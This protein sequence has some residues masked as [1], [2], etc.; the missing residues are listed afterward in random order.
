ME[1]QYSCRYW[2]YHLERSQVLS[3]EIEDLYLFLQKHF[4][5]WVE[6]MSLF[7]LVSKVVGMLDLLHMVV[8]NDETSDLSNFLYDGKRFILKYCQIADEAPLQIYCAGL[9]D[10]PVAITPVWS[11]A[12]SPDSRLLASGSWDNTVRLWDTAT[13]ALQQTFEGHSHYVRSVAFS[14]DG[15]LLASGS[16]DNIVRTWDTA[17]GALQKT[18]EA[19]FWW[20]WSVTFS[21]D[22]R[23]LASGCEDDRVRLW[24]SATGELQHILKGHSN[25]VTSVAFSPDGRLLASGSWD[26]SVCLWDIATGSLQ[27]TWDFQVIVTVFEFSHDGSYLHTS[28]GGIDTQVGCAIS[29]FNSPHANLEISEDHQWIKL[30]GE[31]VLWLPP[32]SRPDCF[33]IKGSKLA[34]G[35]K[36]G[37]VSFIDFCT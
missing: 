28:L 27:Q 22:G 30:N 19:G 8:P 2:I 31:E 3:S 36:S 12:F 23:L 7:G 6:A 9:L 1:I 26:R 21:P 11:V 13:G 32:E 29:T 37:Q 20:V 4:L 34:L 10:M 18:I 17:T 35:Q 24:D 16:Y 14:P 5:H 33:R 15:R 25:S